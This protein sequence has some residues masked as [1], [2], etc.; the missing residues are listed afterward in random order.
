MQMLC[1]R[2]TTIN[3]ADFRCRSAIGVESA[4]GDAIWYHMAAS[5]PLR[6]STLL[7]PP[8]RFRHD[9]PTQSALVGCEPAFDN[10]FSHGHV[11]LPE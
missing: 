11:G 2:S 10:E 4:C 5:L 6:V 3:F 7:T 8:A 9:I 1:R